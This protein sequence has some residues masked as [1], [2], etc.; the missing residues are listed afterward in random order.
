[1][2]TSKMFRKSCTNEAVPI[3][4]IPHTCDIPPPPTHLLLGTLILKPFL[5]IFY[6]AFLPMEVYLNFLSGF[7]NYNNSH[8]IHM[9]AHYLWKNVN[10]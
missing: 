1:M 7:K 6:R 8:C 2:L 3:R 9:H 5:L 10:R 4:C